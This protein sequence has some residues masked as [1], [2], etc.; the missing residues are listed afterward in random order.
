[1]RRQ[2]G[3]DSNYDVEK[4]LWMWLLNGNSAKIDIFDQNLAR[5]GL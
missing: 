2:N 3:A 4:R 5:A 1:M